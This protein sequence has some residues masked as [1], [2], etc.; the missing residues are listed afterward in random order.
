MFSVFRELFI[1]Y[2]TKEFKYKLFQLR[3][4]LRMLAIN[5]NIDVNNWVFEYYDSTISKIINCLKI[6]QYPVN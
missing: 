2:H 3:D 6:F 1:D 5:G 4:D